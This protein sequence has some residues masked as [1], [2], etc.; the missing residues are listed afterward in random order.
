MKLAPL[1]ALVAAFLCVPA[2][3]QIKVIANPNNTHTITFP[4]GTPGGSNNTFTIH[5]PYNGAVPTS[6]AGSVPQNQRVGGFGVVK[7]SPNTMHIV[8]YGDVPIRNSPKK[9]PGVEVKALVPKA[10]FAKALTLGAKVL[11]PVGVLMAAGDIYDLI[12][13]VD[14]SIVDLQSNGNAIHGYRD[15]DGK[16][17]VNP[18][19]VPGFATPMAACVS[20]YGAAPAPGGTV[21]A[22]LQPGGM[23]AWCMGDGGGIQAV[24]TAIAGPGSRELVTQQDI[25]DLVT[26]NTTG[27]PSAA[28]RALASA[29]NAPGVGVQT[30]PLTVTGPATVPG[31]KTTTTETVKLNPGTNTIASP[32]TSPTDTGTKTTTKQDNTKVTYNNNT[33]TTNSTV[34]NTTTTITNN[35]TNVTTT[36]GTKTEETENKDPPKEQEEIVTCGLPGKP[37]CQIDE[38]NTKPEVED[39]AKEDVE[40]KTKPLDDFLKNPESALPTLPTINWA[41]QLPSG[42]SPIALPA[43]EPWLQQID[44]CAFQPLFHDVMSIVWVIGGLFGAI[45]IFW[46]NTFSQG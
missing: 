43:F 5:N 28:A 40:A 15:K 10:A 1:A 6:A 31:E 35:V 30:E 14:P 34:N 8:G 32:G 36:E 26:A 46:R 16:S 33:V 41:F 24:V 17:W 7:T 42:C 20:Y 44:V 39:T 45:G 22:V 18:G 29:L 27:W 21:S 23:N 11:W 2:V 37:K 9:V 3:A 4:N 13:Q 38:L 12:N 25:E 19:N